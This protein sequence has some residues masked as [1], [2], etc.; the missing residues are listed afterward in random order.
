MI[1]WCEYFA[2]LLFKHQHMNVRDQVKDRSV[3]FRS[4]RLDKEGAQGRIAKPPQPLSMYHCWSSASDMH[5]HIESS[6]ML[7]DSPY[8]SCLDHIELNW[9][10][11]V[12]I[13]RM[14]SS[15]I[16][17]CLRVGITVSI[18]KHLVVEVHFPLAQEVV[19]HRI[20]VI[21]FDLF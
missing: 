21:D 11:C 6:F 20:I 16:R 2:T 19:T 4:W 17:L 10:I 18:C 7:S 15:I 1:Q 13:L 9:L 8:L 12:Q 14:M 3:S 5:T